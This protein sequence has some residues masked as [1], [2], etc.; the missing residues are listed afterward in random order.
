MIVLGIDPGTVTGWCVYDSVARRAIAGGEFPEHLADFG[1]YNGRVDVVVI[2]RPKGQGPTRPDVVE[3]GITFGRLM[4]WACGKWPVV[5]ELLRYEIKS[6]LSK[7]TLGEV[8]V[9]T[10]ATAWAALKLI[11][12]EGSDRKAKTR[13]GVEVSP[14]GAIGVLAGSHQRAALAVAVAWVLRDSQ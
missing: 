14:P 7:A 10:D 8:A 5:H 2:E 12:G 1:D 9:R 4:Q 6:I 13:K 3:C 11:H